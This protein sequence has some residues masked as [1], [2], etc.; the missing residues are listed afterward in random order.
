MDYEELLSTAV[1]YVCI[2]HGNVSYAKLSPM[3]TGIHWKL[4]EENTCPLYS[5][6]LAYIKLFEILSLTKI[7]A[8][9]DT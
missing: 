1:N 8:Q 5:I 6:Y 3:L 2:V 7:L 4:S 9:K